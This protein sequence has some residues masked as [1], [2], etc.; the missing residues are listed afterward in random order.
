[1]K[2]FII[3]NQGVVV[4]RNLDS[5]FPTF[6]HPIWKKSDDDDN[7]RKS[8]VRTVM[9]I[10]QCVVCDCTLSVVVHGFIS[11]NHLHVYV[12]LE[13]MLQKFTKRGKIGIQGRNHE[14]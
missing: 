5:T 14:F 7:Q 4:Y 11:I 12:V 8:E 2:P 3:I 13:R 6:K 1:M 9:H 10:F